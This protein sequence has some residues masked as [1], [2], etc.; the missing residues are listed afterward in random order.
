MMHSVTIGVVGAGGDGVVVLGGLLQRLAAAQGYYSQMSRYY[1]P[2]IRGGGSAVKLGLDSERFSMPQDDLDI[3][4]CFA[5]D[6]YWEFEQELPMKA[7]TL[8]VYE[9]TVPQGI[10]LPRESFR[11]DFTERSK[12]ITGS[13]MDKNIVALGMV[14]RVLGI[15][16][17]GVAE[18]IEKDEELRLLR[19]RLAAL[20]E[21]ERIMIDLSLPQRELQTAK[22][23]SPKI[24]LHGNSAVARGALRAGCTAFFGYPITPAA[25]I[26]EEMQRKLSSEGAS[27]LQAEDEITSTNMLL[28]ASLAGIK[29]MTSTSGPGLDLMTETLGLA[30]NAEIPMVVVDVQRCGPSTG[31]PSKSEQS[32]LNHAIYGSHGEAPRVVIAPYDVSSCHRLTIESFNI[33]ERFQTPV[34]LLSDQ[35]LGQT[36]FAIDDFLNSDF[37][38]QDR[39]RPSPK[40]S[41]GYLRYKLTNDYISPMSNAGDE[42]FVYQTSGLTH[43]EMGAPSF[44]A[45]THQLLHEKRWKKLLPLR[46]RDDLVHLFGKD[47]SEIGI[48]SWGSSASFIQETLSDVGLDDRISVCIPQLLCPLPTKVEEYIGSLQRLLVVE[49][50]YSGQLYHY[51]RAHVDLPHDTQVYARAGGRSFSRRELSEPIGRLIQ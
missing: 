40:D 43:D 22:D 21:G 33:A 25:E 42:G 44:D 15:A 4:I 2:Q 19:K 23:Q 8:V 49:M 45:A 30:S 3:L 26:M 47:G 14:N 18:A 50:N 27:Y 1:G 29:A 12:S 16:R 36:L 17:D 38:I 32:D 7:E 11:I 31:I 24:V 20:E 46:E 39:I 34:I 28:G 10:S 37:L 9:Q 41:N 35:W 48:V 13:T 5:W 51:L 6:K